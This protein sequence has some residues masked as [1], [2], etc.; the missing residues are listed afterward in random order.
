[1]TDMTDCRVLIVDK[2]QNKILE[3][4]QEALDPLAQL[5]V[6][7]I[8]NLLDFMAL[9]EEIIVTTL[10]NVLTDIVASFH[11]SLKAAVDKQKEFDDAVKKALKEASS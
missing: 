5:I 11:P 9:V 3:T 4:T 8:D 7:P 10:D 2:I 1:M 6:A